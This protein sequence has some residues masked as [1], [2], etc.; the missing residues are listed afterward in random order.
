MDPM[1]VLG[2]GS[3]IHGKRA[4]QG[5]ALLK[6]AHLTMDTV[7]E[8]YCYIRHVQTCVALFLYGALCSAPFPLAPAP[9]P[10]HIGGWRGA[11]WTT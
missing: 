3:R 9:P 7:C 6:N 8:A 11:R 5:P 2:N 1:E 4:S 10:S